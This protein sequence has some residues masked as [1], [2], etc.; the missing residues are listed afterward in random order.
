MEPGGVEVSNERTTKR[1]GGLATR[2]VHDVVEIEAVETWEKVDKS[3]EC[4]DRDCA[5]LEG[6]LRKT[7][8]KS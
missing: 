7:V 2:V 5:A 6:Q 8:S 3:D 1:G 4:A